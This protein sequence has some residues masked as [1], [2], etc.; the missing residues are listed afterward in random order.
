M[1]SENIREDFLA[2]KNG[3]TQLTENDLKVLDD[4]YAVVSPKHGQEEG[5]PPFSDQLQK[6]AEHILPIVDG[7]PKEALGTTFAKIKQIIMSIHSCGYFDQ[8]SVTQ[9]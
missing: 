2:G 1:G 3:A 6:A 4:V 7:R 9:V 5:F 8:V